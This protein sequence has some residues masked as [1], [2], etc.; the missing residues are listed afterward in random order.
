MRL[1]MSF[2]RWSFPIRAGQLG[3]ALVGSVAALVYL[4]SGLISVEAA[5]GGLAGALADNALF[6]VLLVRIVT[7]IA[8]GTVGTV[9]LIQRPVVG[10]LV[11][12]ATAVVSELTMPSAMW[13]ASATLYSVAGALALRD[14]RQSPPG[15]WAAWARM[16]R[17]R[18]LI[19]AF[20]MLSVSLAGLGLVPTLLSCGVIGADGLIWPYVALWAGQSGVVAV[21]LGISALNL[22]NRASQGLSVLLAGLLIGSALTVIGAPGGIV[23][24]YARVPGAVPTRHTT[25]DQAIPIPTPEPELGL[26]PIPAQTTLTFAPASVRLAPGETAVIRLNITTDTPVQSLAF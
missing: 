3:L 16:P 5:P 1:P 15:V 21:A 8:F 25:G 24:I 11:L 12:I 7:A 20:G 4:I 6:R 22:V 10:G 18:R 17:T 26:T 14:A 23:T 13:S 9:L 19:V 2:P